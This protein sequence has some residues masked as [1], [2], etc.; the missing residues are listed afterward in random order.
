MS[1]TARV[2]SQQ[3]RQRTAVLIALIISLL[4]HL[5]IIL[6]IAFLLS[7]QPAPPE[8]PKEEEPLTLTLIEPPPPKPD[9]TPY[10]RTTRSQEITE[11]PDDAAFESDKNTAAASPLAPTGNLPL[12][13]QQG[14]DS[15]A[16]EFENREY[17][18]GSQPRESAPAAPPSQPARPTEPTRPQT[19]PEEQQ[20]EPQKPKPTPTPRIGEIALLQPT[21]PKQ[22]PKPQEEPHQTPRPDSRP[23]PQPGYQ[24]QTRIT[25]L[26]GG[27]D[28]RKGRP[29]VAARATP[30]GR[31]KK[32]VSDAIGSRW[33][34]YVNSRLSLLQTGRVEIRFVVTPSGKVEKVRVLSNT[35]NESFASTS[36]SAIIEA[37]IPPI[38]DEILPMLEG[39]QI[40]IDYTFTILPN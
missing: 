6:G 5:I 30:L 10:I 25:R 40:E 1:E 38:P 34:Y 39:E 8:P 24:P 20:P 17:T 14:E 26:R 33:Y 4:L 13:S 36:V 35:S 3:R 7:L 23:A 2:N 29:S 9:S 32:A 27:I 19:E 31:Y 28:N 16:I 12:P 18:P 11:A 21:Q 15:P 37:E 22:R